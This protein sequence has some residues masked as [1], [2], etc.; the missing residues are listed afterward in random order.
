MGVN[1]HVLN[2]PNLNLLGVREP[3]I[4][5]VETL[6]D[7]EAQCAEHGKKI[8]AVVTCKQSNHE[9]VLIDWIHQARLEANGVIINAGAYTHTSMAI[10]DALRA[11]EIP[12]IEVHISNVFAREEYRHHS[13]ITPLA[14]GFIGGFGRMGYVMALDAIASMVEI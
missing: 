4:Y 9:G 1:I 11:L 10:H 13:F 14:R 5:G 6:Q 7:L 12:I 8:G 2:G 3:S